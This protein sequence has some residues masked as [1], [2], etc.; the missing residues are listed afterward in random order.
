MSYFAVLIFNAT[1]MIYSRKITG[2]DPFYQDRSSPFQLGSDVFSTP[3]WTPIT[4]LVASQT[5]FDRSQTDLC[6]RS[7]RVILFENS[8][9]SWNIMSWPLLWCWQA[10]GTRRLSWEG[11]CDDVCVCR[12]REPCHVKTSETNSLLSSWKAGRKR[13]LEIGHVREFCKNRDVC[14]TQ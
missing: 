14:M 5:S 10:S 4:H 9:C 7:C 8:I 11:V 1:L 13:G 6:C 3:S 2:G 12:K